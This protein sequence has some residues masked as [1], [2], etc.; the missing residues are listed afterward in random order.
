MHL[1]YTGCVSSCMCACV[2]A[3]MSL[4]TF[5][6]VYSGGVSELGSYLGLYCLDRFIM[7]VV[8]AVMIT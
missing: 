4:G 8:S 6:H 5:F 2:C 7:T 3:L 1:N